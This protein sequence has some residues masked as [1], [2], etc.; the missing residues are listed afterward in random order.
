MLKLDVLATRSR[1]DCSSTPDKSQEKQFVK[2]KLLVN[3]LA[4]SAGIYNQLAELLLKIEG[5]TSAKLRGE[6]RVT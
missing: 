5:E 1:S 2:P 4:M 3:P 6:E